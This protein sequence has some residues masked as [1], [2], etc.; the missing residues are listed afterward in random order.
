M[1]NYP[2][3]DRSYE[4]GVRLA[5]LRTNAPDNKRVSM[6]RPALNSQEREAALAAI[7]PA[8]RLRI[9]QAAR[10]LFAD[11]EFHRVKL[12]DIARSAR[13]SLQTL[14]KYYG[15][16]ENV[17][18]ASLET[19]LATL[20]QRMLDHLQGIEGYRDRL[21]KVFWVLLDYFERN[22]EVAQI[23]MS[24]VYLNTWRF[25]DTFRQPELMSVF[26]DVIREGREAGVLTTTVDEVEI[27]DFIWGVANRSVAMWLVR[28][29]QDSL[30]NRSGP[31][32]DMLWQAIA[33]DA[34]LAERYAT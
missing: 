19:W 13:I 18:F 33:S 32:F 9:E 4:P 1:C 16:K 7:D 17:L 21:R 31:L 10:E 5:R 30:S 29:Q 26:L 12:I 20:T 27:S 15:N 3:G 8:T 2:V 22:P 23:I 34:T 6:Q 11:N 14:Y 24:S 25:D 28:G